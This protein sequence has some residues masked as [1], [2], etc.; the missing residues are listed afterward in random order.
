MQLT[1]RRKKKRDGPIRPTAAIITWIL[2][3]LIWMVAIDTATPH[4]VLSADAGHR[5]DYEMEVPSLLGAE[6]R[7]EISCSFAVTHNSYQNIS[8]HWELWDVEE[9]RDAEAWQEDPTVDDPPTPVRQWTGG[10]AEDCSDDSGTI[11][12]GDYLLEI[13]FSHENGSMISWD[14]AARNVRGD[15]RMRYWIYEAHAELGY[16]AANIL[17]L[18]ILITDQAVRRIRR[19]IRLNRV[20]PLHRQRD[21]EDWEVLKKEMEGRGEAVIE[22]FQIEMGS[23]SEAAREEMR[24]RFAAQSLD[25]EEDG[26]D[27]PEEGGVKQPSELGEGTTEGLTGKAKVGRDI[28]TVGDLWKRMKDEK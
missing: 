14:E 2:L 22:S 15:F 17:G 24:K 3:N 27:R 9:K 1:G 23:S 21:R 19:K 6:P 7:F 13:R 28:R 18:F 12:P 5:Q 20:I 11:A 10:P 8:I 25:G 26:Q 16:I 4:P